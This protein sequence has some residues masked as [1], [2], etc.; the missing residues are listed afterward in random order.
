MNKTKQLVF[1]LLF[2]LFIP[3]VYAFSYDFEMQV[4]DSGV[5]FSEEKEVKIILKDVVE[6]TSSSA[7]CSMNVQVFDN[8]SLNGTFLIIGNWNVRVTENFY[9]FNTSD[10]FSS[11]VEMFSIPVKVG[12]FGSIK[13][14]NIECTNDN[15]K[16]K[17]ED[18]VLNFNTTDIEDKFVDIDIEGIDFG[19]NQ[20]IY[21]YTIYTTNYDGLEVI[22]NTEYEYDI[23]REVI[24]D[25]NAIIVTVDRADDIDS[26]KYTIYVNSGLEN[27]VENNNNEEY[28]SDTISIIIFIIIISALVLINVI[29]II[30]KLKK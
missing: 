16:L 11:D 2:S 4:N 17:I 1:L 20:N 21:E 6:T 18:K 26:Y 22:V 24:D 27:S 25:K 5:S 12:D 3:K 13:L 30:K 19:F 29:R 8:V 28:G 10:S 9:E 23:K 7:N 15:N 14:T